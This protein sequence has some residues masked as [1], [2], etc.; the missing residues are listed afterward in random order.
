MEIKYW[1]L[2][3]FCLWSAVSLF[4]FQALNKR[5][6]LVSTIVPSTSCEALHIQCALII[7]Q[8]QLLCIF[9]G[10]KIS[11]VYFTLKFISAFQKMI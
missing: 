3:K 5:N 4:I 8:F 6:F 2:L 11:I 7:S 10:R 1:R 9:R